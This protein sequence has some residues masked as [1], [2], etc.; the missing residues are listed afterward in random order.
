MGDRFRLSLAVGMLVAVTACTDTRHV[1]FNAFRGDSGNPLVFTRQ[2]AVQIS[3]ETHAAPPNCLIVLPVEAEV[4]VPNAVLRRIEG[5]IVANLPRDLHVVFGNRRTTESSRRSIDLRTDLGQ[6]AFA[7]SIDCPY[8][9][10]ARVTSA[11]RDYLLV[12]ARLR[13]GMEASMTRVP[14]EQVLWRARHEAMRTEG[15]AALTPV[16]AVIESALT[17]NFLADDDQVESLIDDLVRRLFVSFP[18]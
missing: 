15:G 11:A 8:L 2:V 4:P 1:P 10:R 9:L 6:S 13:L 3:E 17:A 14:G 18:E 12:W 16:G 5:R 7:R